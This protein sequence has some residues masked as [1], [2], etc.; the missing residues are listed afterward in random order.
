[1]AEGNIVFI[2]PDG[3][4]EVSLNDGVNVHA[5]SVSGVGMAQ[6]LNQAE[7]VP[8]EDGERYVRT[9]LGPR[10]IAFDLVIT[11][12]SWSALHARR[13]ALITALNPRRGI[14]TLRWTPVSGGAVYAIAA[15]LERGFTLA[16]SSTPGPLII[17]DA[18]SFRCPDP[19]WRSNVLVTTNLTP[20]AGGMAVPTDVPTELVD[21]G[22]TVV[23]AN[24][25]DLDSYPVVTFTGPCVG[26][27][28][29]NET[30][31]K[32][33]SFPLLI[34]ASGETL[35]IDMAARTA[36]IGGLSVLSKRRSGDEF[37]ALVPGN[38]TIVAGTTSGSSTVQVK[39]YP[40]Y[41]GV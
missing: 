25:G 30:T 5:R 20:A 7:V 38:N 37:W 28:I 8:L 34:L 2:A 35:T 14:G 21:G 32:V 17:N 16:E 41:A 36:K 29:E 4:T 39:Y 11:D 1:M 15:I 40:R 13:R 6:P 31:G 19:G 27:S 33:C 9:L 3:I 23:I 26:P 24:A 22:G 12:T 10:F 18:V